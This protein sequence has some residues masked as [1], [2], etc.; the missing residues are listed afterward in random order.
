MSE[1]PGLFR[2]DLDP[3]H[4]VLGWIE[5]GLNYVRGDATLPIRPRERKNVEKA[6]MSEPDYRAMLIA[7]CEAIEE[8]SCEEYGRMYLPSAV[9]EWW[10][11]DPKLERQREAEARKAQIESARW[12]LRQARAKAKAAEDEAQAWR[13]VR[14]DPSEFI[15]QNVAGAEAEA[16]NAAARVAH[17]EAKLKALADKASATAAPQAA[18]PARVVADLEASTPHPIPHESPKEGK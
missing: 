17:L 5:L 15:S 1:P 3:A 12:E 4:R 9:E 2:P 16:A 18:D 14:A 10:N 7:V 6:D 11:S 8:H 13:D